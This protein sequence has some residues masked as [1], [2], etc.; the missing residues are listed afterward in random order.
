M[1][2]SPTGETFA[3][4]I[5]TTPVGCESVFGVRPA[6][7][8]GRVV[9]LAEAWPLAER[10]RRRMLHVADPEAMLD[11]VLDT[12]GWSLRPPPRGIELCERAVEQLIDDPARPISAIAV[13]LGVSQEHLDREFTSVAGLSPRRL[14][15]LM[16]VRRLLE[17][18]EVRDSVDWADEAIRRGWYDQAHL[19]RDFKRYTGV[20]PTS[21]VRAQLT[22][23]SDEELAKDRTA[24]IAGCDPGHTIVLESVQGPVTATYTYRLEP[25]EATASARG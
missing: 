23:S 9:D 5:V 16:R 2:N 18:I 22:A 3:V 8:A 1:S 24:A 19:I 7:F 25:D 6:E 11:I 21:Y 4:G 13:S 14:A 15:S 10:I 20:T 17:Q 12:V